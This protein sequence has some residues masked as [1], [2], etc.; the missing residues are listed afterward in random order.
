MRL[1]QFIQA[2]KNKYNRLLTSLISLYLLSPFL[3]DRPIGDFIVFFVFSLSLV[4][5]VY[6][7]DRAKLEF[8]VHIG[9]VFLALILR[10]IAALAP[11]YSSFNHW[12]ELFST[13][14]FLA[15][16]GLSVYS[17]LR[18]LILAGQVTSDI[19]KGGICIY[20]LFGFFWAATY[21]IVHIFDADSFSS[22][23]EVITNADLF[24]FSFTTLTTIGY[25]DI[26]PA[27]KTARVLANLE[28]IVGVMYPTVF[29]ARL[30]NLRGDR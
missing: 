1:R 8:R 21:N 24:H 16:I 11:I 3:V 2:T 19:I 30:V 6:Q 13:L 18:E 26:S 29:I 25:G 4:V 20:F 17:I 22:A 28:G 27:S 9:L 23:S 7:I 10:T 12:F 5:V 14:I 15:F